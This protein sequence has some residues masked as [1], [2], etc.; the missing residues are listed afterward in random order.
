MFLKHMDGALRLAFSQPNAP[1][2]KNLLAQKVAFKVDRLRFLR[3]RSLREIA[4]GWIPVDPEKAIDN[5]GFGNVIFRD[6]VGAF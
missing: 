6:G 1:N 4:W 2:T 3:A 5:H